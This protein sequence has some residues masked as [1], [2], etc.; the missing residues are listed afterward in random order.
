MYVNHNLYTNMDAQKSDIKLFNIKSV[1]QFKPC[2]E[3]W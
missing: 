3:P 1:V 2:F